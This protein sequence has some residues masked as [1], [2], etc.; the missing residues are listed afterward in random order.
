MNYTY[1]LSDT[2]YIVFKTHNDHFE[3]YSGHEGGGDLKKIANYKGG[4]WLFDSFDQKKLFWFLFTMFKN[5][6]GKALKKYT[7]S[8]NEKPKTYVIKCAKRR[9]DIKVQKIKRGWSNWFYSFYEG[10]RR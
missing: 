7:K 8:L 4:K 5:D 6:F 1:N 2:E 10:N 3:L 9:F